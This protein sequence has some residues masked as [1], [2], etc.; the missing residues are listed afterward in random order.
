MDRK[1]WLDGIE[2]FLKM[3]KNHLGGEE[4]EEFLSEVDDLVDN[5]RTEEEEVEEDD[6]DN[7]EE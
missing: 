3:A 1:T 6:D 2:G 5:A 7:E 4:Y